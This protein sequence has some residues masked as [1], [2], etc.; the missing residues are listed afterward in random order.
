M[1]KQEFLKPLPWY[2]LGL[3]TIQILNTLMQLYKTVLMKREKYENNRRT[4]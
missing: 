4:N 1:I 2:L 3:V